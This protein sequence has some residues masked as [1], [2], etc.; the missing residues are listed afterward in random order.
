[1]YIGFGVSR[2]RRDVQT[3]EHVACRGWR[4]SSHSTTTLP[5]EPDDRER[6][7]ITVTVHD[8]TPLVKITVYGQPIS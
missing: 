4:E 5:T 2:C 1:M 7:G 8:I 6:T 3:L